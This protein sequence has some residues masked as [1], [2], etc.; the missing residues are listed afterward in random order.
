M[1]PLPQTPAA[2]PPAAHFRPITTI[3]LATD[4]T[5]ASAE[6][7]ERA[8]DLAARLDARLLVV[9]VLEHR[10]LGGG[11]SHARVDQARAERETRLVE[12]VRRA[13]AGG[14]KA[15]FM[16]WTGDPGSGIASV[17]EAEA[18]DLVVVGTRGRSGAERMLLGSVSD[19]VVR[20]AGCPVLVVRPVERQDD[21]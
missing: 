19:H 9:N 1:T 13:R 11:G 6:A 14:A 4:L 12:L 17:A 5:P 3:L 15:E 16:V 8:I 7:T 20:T 21:T 2:P 10:R 18:A